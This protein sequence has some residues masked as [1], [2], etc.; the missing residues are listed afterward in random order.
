MA[1]LL[2][3]E[4]H[5]D[6]HA[7]SWLCEE[8]QENM[9]DEMATAHRKSKFSKSHVLTKIQQPQQEDGP[10]VNISQSLPIPICTE[11]QKPFR[12]YDRTCKR[13]LCADECQFAAEHAT[14]QVVT[15]LKEKA[16]RFENDDKLWKFCDSLDTDSI[17]HQLT[18]LRQAGLNRLVKAEES[19]REALDRLEADFLRVPRLIQFFTHCCKIPF[20]FLQFSFLRIAD[21]TTT[22]CCCILGSV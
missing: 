7:A 9:C 2:W 3:C 6:R 11:H 16:E 17:L 21:S 13:L 4:L 10:G 8:C 22:C 20:H 15:L 19:K 14:C 1:S 5:D 12:M 18:L